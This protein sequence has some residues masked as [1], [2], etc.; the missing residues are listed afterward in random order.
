MEAEQARMRPMDA[1]EARRRGWNDERGGAGEADRESPR[2]RQANNRETN[3]FGDSPKGIHL[4]RL[5][6]VLALL[7]IK[8]AIISFPA[9]RRETGLPRPRAFSGTCDFLNGNPQRAFPVPCYRIDTHMVGTIVWE[10]LHGQVK[11]ATRLPSG[12][13]HRPSSFLTTVSL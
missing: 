8:S 12:G 4:S 2:R 1:A 10:A 13:R 6:S 3:S 7:D 5:F 11:R 9:S